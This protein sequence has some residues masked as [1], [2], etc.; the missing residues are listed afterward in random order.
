MVRYWKDL[1]HKR[2]AIVALAVISANLTMV[3]MLMLWWGG[4]SYGPRELTDTIR[5][6]LL[7]MLGCHAFLGGFIDW[8]ATG[9]RHY[10]RGPGPADAQRGDECAPALC[11]VRPMPG[12]P[13]PISK[14]IRTAC[15]IGAMRSFWPRSTQLR[16]KMSGTI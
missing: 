13:G 5:L 4:W 7:A 14:S 3:S 8:P 10:R 16:H 11:P 2:L 1:K 15:G 6:S 12:T 9:R